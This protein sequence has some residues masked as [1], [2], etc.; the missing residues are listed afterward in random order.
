MSKQKYRKQRELLNHWESFNNTY[1]AKVDD[2]SLL[3]FLN[4]LI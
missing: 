1:L 3:P 2:Y 4:L